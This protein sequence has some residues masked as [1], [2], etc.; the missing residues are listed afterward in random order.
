MRTS[1]NGQRHCLR[2]SLKRHPAGKLPAALIIPY[3]YDESKRLRVIKGREG[4][5]W[6]SID[7]FGIV[8]IWHLQVICDFGFVLGEGVGGQGYEILQSGKLFI[9]HL[10]DIRLKISVTPHSTVILQFIPLL[11]NLLNFHHGDQR[12][13]HRDTH[14]ASILLL[15]KMDLTFLFENSRSTN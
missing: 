1:Q 2:P 6:D 12:H 3:L 15:S 13:R 7:W 14:P 11:Q 5:E 8:L 4:R 10:L 9:S